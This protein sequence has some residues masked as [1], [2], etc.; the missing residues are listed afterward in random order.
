M[1]IILSKSV[2]IARKKWSDGLCMIGHGN[3]A[4]EKCYSRV[5]KIMRVQNNKKCKD[6]RSMHGSETK[7]STVGIRSTTI[8]LLSS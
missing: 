4:F 5:G 6:K 2:L 3:P 8:G 7:C 1:A